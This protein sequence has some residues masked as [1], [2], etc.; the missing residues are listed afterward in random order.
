MEQPTYEEIRRRV[1]E[2]E[3]ARIRKSDKV[4]DGLRKEF[5]AQSEIFH[6]ENWLAY[7]LEDAEL[8][9]QRYRKFKHWKTQV[10]DGRWVSIGSS[11]FEK[12]DTKAFD[13]AVD[14]LP[15]PGQEYQ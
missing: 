2:L 14:A 10:Q 5:L 6:Y 1:E 13:D 7:R 15:E 12:S 3:A 9:A 4:Q 8:D 11:M